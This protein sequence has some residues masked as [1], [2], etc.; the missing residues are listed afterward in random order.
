[1]RV[2]VKSV[3]WYLI[4]NYHR[5]LFHERT[6]VGIQKGCKVEKDAPFFQL[7]KL[8]SAVVTQKSWLIAKKDFTKAVNLLQRHFLPDNVYSSQSKY[9]KGLRFPS[10]NSSIKECEGHEFVSSCSLQQKDS[11]VLLKMALPILL[12]SAR[13]NKATE[14][15]IQLTYCFNES[16]FRN[17]EEINENLER[18][19]RAWS[20]LSR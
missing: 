13:I 20:W 6:G 18:T 16:P 19:R 8:L 4:P 9:F 11:S 1:M 10:G 7:D 17:H 14:L 2:C 5:Q 3:G 12:T 15:K